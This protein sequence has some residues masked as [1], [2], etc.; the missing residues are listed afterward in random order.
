MGIKW[1]MTSDSSTAQAF[2][3]GD[4]LPFATMTTVKGKLDVPM[5]CVFHDGLPMIA[6]QVAEYNVA[7]YVEVQSK[8]G[9]RPF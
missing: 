8:L 5:V 1:A 2:R 7:E 9:A 4:N 3:D 6:A